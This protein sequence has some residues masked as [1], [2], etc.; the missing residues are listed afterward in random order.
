MIYPVC[1]IGGGL[2]GS[3]CAW[4]LARAGVPVALVEMRPHKMTPAHQT[5]ELAELVCSNSLR[6]GDVNNAVGLLKEEMAYLN[7][8]IIQAANQTKVPAG[9]ALAVDREEFAKVVTHQLQSQSFITRVSGVVQQIE[10]TPDCLEIVLESKDRIA[11]K[12]CVIA[13]GPLTDDA[14]ARWILEQTNQESLYFYDSIAPIVDADSID[15]SVAF[16]ANRYDKGEADGDYINCPMTKEQYDG[17]LKELCK[18]DLA[19]VHEFD[20]Q[21]FFEGCLP[22]EEIARRGP[23]TLCF[24][25]MKPVGLT[26]PHAPDQ[27][28]H[29]V[30]QLRQDNRH[31]SL[32]NMVGFQTRMKIGEQ[33]RVFQMI[34]GLE[35]AEFVRMGSMHRNTYICSPRLLDD[36]FQFK[37]IPNV[38]FAGQITG[39]EGYVESAA[40]GLFVGLRL[41]ALIHDH[42]NIFLPPQTTALG[43]LC[44]HVLKADEKNFQPMNIN[45]GLFEPL[46][47]SCKK[48]DKKRIKVLRAREDFKQWMS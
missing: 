25:P 30:V 26:N 31:A 17:F 22:I 3:E 46:K 32:F 29:A 23:E 7:S 16:C 41:L 2:A 1:I 4:Q 42:K 13:T 19:P 35:R 6:S 5:G 8:L 39:C 14:L 10:S 44:Q 24:G 37:K 43:A 33:R 21:K 27:R 38:Y 20:H 47:E 12:R 45:F 11:C 18:A 36:C 40:V 34:P 48:R 28:M 15:M 9:S